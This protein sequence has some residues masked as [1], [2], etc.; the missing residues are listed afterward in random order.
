MSKEIA[1][2]RE[3]ILSKIYEIKG[4]K[5][6]LDKDLAELYEVET[7]VLKQAVK[8]NIDI[9]PEHFM[10]ELTEEEHESLRSQIVTSKKGR[11][12]TRYLPMVFTEHGILQVAHVLRSKRAR[13]MSVRIT[14]IFIKMREIIQTHQELFTQMSEIRKKVSGQEEQITLIFEYLKQLEQAKQEELE[15]KS[16]KRIGFKQQEE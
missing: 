2:P 16:R 8:R 9:F 13:Y 5:V 12:G 1:I 11:G 3:V 6:I 14:E 7:K 4:Q 15:H 10:F